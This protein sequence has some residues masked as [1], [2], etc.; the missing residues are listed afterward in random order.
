MV[1]RTAT[2]APASSRTKL[3][4][5]PSQA[6]HPS[7]RTIRNSTS[8]RSFAPSTGLGSRNS[9]RSSGWTIATMSP[10]ESGTSSN[11]IPSTSA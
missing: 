3:P 1:P 6:M 7:A 10:N 4:L 5:Q 9:T 2:T 8:N 11:G